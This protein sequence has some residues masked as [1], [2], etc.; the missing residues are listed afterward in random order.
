MQT[1]ID[2]WRKSYGRVI[3]ITSDHLYAYV[4]HKGVLHCIKVPYDMR[5]ELKVKDI[6][7]LVDDDMGKPLF[8]KIERSLS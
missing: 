1:T 4:F 3:S 5:N 8:Y 7:V 6:V 2:H